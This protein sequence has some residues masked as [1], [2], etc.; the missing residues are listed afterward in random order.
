MTRVARIPDALLAAALGLISFVMLY[1]RYW[2]PPEKIFDEVYFARAAEEYLQRRYIYESTHP[3]L[4]KLLVTLSTMLF[5]GLAHGD[6]AYGW[7]FLNVVAGAVAVV[8]LFLLARRILR[9]SMFAV[10]AS[11]LFMADG[12]HY[13]QSR[14]ATPEGFVVCFSLATLYAFCRY[15]DAVVAHPST[16]AEPFEWL[17]HG[18]ETAGALALAAAFTWARFAPETLT[19]K[20]IAT[21]LI[22]AGIYASYRIVRERP[23]GAGWMLAFAFSAAML[24]AS[25]WYGVMAYGVAAAVVGYVSVRAWIA[26][27]N[28]PFPTGTF[29]AT[30]IA[31][32][33]IVYALVYTPHFIGLRDLQTLPPRAYTWSNVVDMQV[34]AYEYHAH[35]VATHPYASLWWT[36]PLDLRPIL[37]YAKYENNTAA[38][39][40]SLPNPLLLWSGLFGV[41]F[42]GWLAW[43]TWNR[44]YALV[45][46]T[47]LMQWLPWARSPRLAWEYHFYVNI[48]LIALCNTIAIKW[49][50]EKLKPRDEII[51]RAI[52]IGY[53]AIIV[54]AFVYFFPIYAGLTIPSD[55][56]MQR[57]WLP[58]WV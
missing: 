21:I 41:A 13:V 33:G 45:V 23:V 35:L 36:W 15:W 27:K 7:R 28:N 31:A 49:I 8:L 46:L 19:A 42:T 53:L 34:G 50:Y 55:A 10:Y 3:P 1:V 2:F 54:A 6:T 48:P 58:S 20:I 52:A 39:I 29:V 5:G 17:R 37:Y 43:R 30:A 18:V 40:Y 56:R 14:I 11:L 22:G 32:V 24:V 47:Y 38:M 51:A 12:M 4:T 25:K 16:D 44:G 57:M 9:S 26:G